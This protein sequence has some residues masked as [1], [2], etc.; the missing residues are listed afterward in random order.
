MLE[1][2]LL[3]PAQGLDLTNLKVTGATA[4]GVAYNSVDK[5]Y[6]VTVPAISASDVLTPNL[7]DGT[8]ERVLVGDL[9]YKGAGDAFTV[10]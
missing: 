2:N 10:A 5:N 9:I 3:T 8:Y 6:T 1:G 7:N 4:S